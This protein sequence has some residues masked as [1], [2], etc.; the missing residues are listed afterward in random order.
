MKIFLASIIL[1]MLSSCSF[2]NKT[3]IWENSSET[4]EEKDKTFKDYADASWI[5]S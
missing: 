2:D 5:G 3:G 4:A 1:I